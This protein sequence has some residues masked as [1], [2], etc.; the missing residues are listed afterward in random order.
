[1]A[2]VNGKAP[3]AGARLITRTALPFGPCAAA[4]GATLSDLASIPLDDAP[5]IS[6]HGNGDG[7]QD[8]G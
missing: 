1:V 7:G 3:S 5:T 2:A 4:A 8:D 6:G